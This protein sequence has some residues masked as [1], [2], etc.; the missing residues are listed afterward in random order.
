MKY[1][2]LT[3]E[4]F[5][6]LH[7]EFANFLA[8]QQ[9]DKKEWEAIK[10]DTPNIAEDELDIFSDLIWEGVMKNTKFVEHFSQ[11]HV[12]LFHCQEYFM[13]TIVIKSLDAQVNFLTNEGLEWLGNNLF[14]QNVELLR[15]KKDYTIDRN[16]EIFKLIE[17][18][19]ILSDGQLF[20]QV[21][22]LI[23]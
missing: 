20:M 8:S 9:I 16:E 17:Q 12:F 6:S 22:S 19:A 11:R 10:K 7:E 23:E 18:G 13:Q 4:Q 5:D 3:K 21:N 2:R 15:G 14:T 1:K